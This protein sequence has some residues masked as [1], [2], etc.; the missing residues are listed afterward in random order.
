[1][2]RMLIAWKSHFQSQKESRLC[3]MV[4]LSVSEGQ[5]TRGRAQSRALLD[6]VDKLVA[7]RP[8]FAKL[9]PR[10]GGWRF[11]RWV[12]PILVCEVEFRGWTADGLVR[13][14]SF[15][16]LREDKPAEDVVLERWKKTE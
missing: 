12:R 1:L 8:P 2:L 3:S 4:L 11:V 16:G 13:Q 7:A 5:R 9:L 14:G 10:G 6:A 15:K